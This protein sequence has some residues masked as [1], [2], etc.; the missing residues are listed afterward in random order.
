M[1]ISKIPEFYY[2]RGICSSHL[3]TATLIISER[4][5]KAITGFIKLDGGFI[6]LLT[7]VRMFPLSFLA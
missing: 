3:T 2:P 1:A 5:F 6:R 7:C 4:R